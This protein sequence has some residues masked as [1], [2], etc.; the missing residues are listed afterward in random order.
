VPAE[1]TIVPAA[2]VS[3]R[4]ESPGSARIGID[5]RKFAWFRPLA[6]DYAYHYQNVASLYA[7]DP[8]S[9]DAWRAAIA[10]RQ[11]HHRLTPAGSR[12]SSKRSRSAAAPRPPLARPRRRSPIPALSPS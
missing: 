8:A 9:P 10:R 1:P 12:G 6:G 2:D 3:E 4:P 7:G 11:Q 5:V